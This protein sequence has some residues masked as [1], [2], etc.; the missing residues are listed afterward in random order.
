MTLAITFAAATT[1]P[2]TWTTPSGQ[3]ATVQMPT[4]LHAAY[5][6]SEHTATVVQLA[7]AQNGVQP[8]VTQASTGGVIGLG[9]ATLLGLGLLVWAVAKWR[10]GWGK[11]HKTAF[12]MGAA[13]AVLIGSWGIFG[14]LTNTVKTTGDSVGN[15]VGTTIS[16]QTSVT[17]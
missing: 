16:Q 10:H 2:V 15:S 13:A 17:R 11:E 8:A 3:A 12:L 6:S 9:G 1:V 4:Q 7:D 5:G 14:Q